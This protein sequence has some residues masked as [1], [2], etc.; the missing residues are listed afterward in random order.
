VV[1]SVAVVRLAAVA[2]VGNRHLS[3]RSRFVS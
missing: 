3:S 1:C 2:A